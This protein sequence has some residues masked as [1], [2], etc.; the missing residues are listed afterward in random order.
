MFA[1]RRALSDPG[2]LAE[3]MAS[4]REGRQVGADVPADAGALDFLVR[5]G[6]AESLQDAA[7][8]FCR[9]EPGV[10]VVLSGTGNVAHLEANA[11]SLN[12]PPLPEEDLARVRDMFAG[13]D[14]VSGN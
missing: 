13:V 10:H 6:G 1:V 5:E 14:D 4:L 9:Y 8:R 3:V 11:A 12:R 7:Y 2:V